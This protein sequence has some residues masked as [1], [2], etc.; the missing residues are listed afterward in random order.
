MFHA[1]D[2]TLRRDM[3]IWDYLRIVRKWWWLALIAAFIGGGAGYI[4]NF[5]QPPF[6]SSR[7]VVS[8]GRT[9]DQ[10]N[11]AVA[12]LNFG[13]VL[14]PTYVQLLR[15]RDLL[16][17]VVDQVGLPV[18]TNFISASF[19]TNVPERTSLLEI[20]ATTSDPLL[21][22]NIANALADQLL[23]R[24]PTNLSI[25]QQQQLDLATSQM[26]ALIDQVALQRT[27][28]S[29]YEAQL[30]TL[31]DDAAIE[32]VSNL[33]SNLINQIND[34]T[35]SI[36]Q[37]Q[38]TITQIQRQTNTLTIVERALPSN[39]P[40][41]PDVLTATLLGAI[42][43]A[44]LIAG[45]VVVIE[46]LDD[47]V[48][49]PQVAAQTLG[50]PVLGAI[51][52]FGNRAMPYPDRL[53]SRRDSLSPES[54]A[55]RRLR[56]NLMFTANSKMHEKPVFIVTSAGPSEGKSVTTANLAV[57]LALAGVDVLLVD[58]DLRR[59]RVHEIF[60]LQNDI[61]LTTLLMAD[62]NGGGLRDDADEEA[63]NAVALKSL[64]ECLQYTSVPKLRV[65]TSGFTPNNPTE[66]LG[67]A[68]MHRWL[69]VFRSA[70]NIDI[71]IIDTPP[72]LLFTDSSVLASI[73]STDVILVI[74]GRKT[75][76]GAVMQ[77]KANFEQLGV[78]IKGV[79]MNRLDPK[80]QGG[81]YSYNYEYGYYY[82]PTK[83]G[84]NGK[85]ER[86]GLLRLR[87]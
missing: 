12:D 68:L 27:A 84:A 7:A 51:P 13:I 10:Q 85:G 45:V 53:I 41:R 1:D 74:D 14:A 11:F 8:I 37:F 73:A 71:V 6:Y 26:E 43:G 21:S 9:V 70:S 19:T 58:A 56:T 57:T 32:R 31:T 64:N 67:S 78:K 42:V 55:Y 30:V 16:Q 34:A 79:I 36:V 75:R 77:T 28:V 72:A 35:A 50:L 83:A 4:T 62:Q 47:R 39:N 25:E 38:Q 44:A 59:P 33:R 20:N 22:A 24:S 2:L 46:Y 63:N 29:E 65:I 76:R 40:R 80:E 87:R 69:A 61:G 48:K 5:R 15:T 66:I 60:E 3:E 86:R 23:L 18:S 49:T 54:E 82:N 81:Y 52:Q 17:G